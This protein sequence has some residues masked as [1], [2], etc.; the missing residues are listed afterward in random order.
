MLKSTLQ[1]GGNALGVF[2][3]KTSSYKY[4]W[5]SYY[6]VFTVVFCLR[7]FREDLPKL[8]YLTQ[9]IK[10][11]LRLNPP[12]IMIQRVTNEPM[13]MEGYE[14]PVGTMIN[15][16]IINILTNETTWEE[17]FVSIWV[18]CTLAGDDPPFGFNAIRK[19]QI[20]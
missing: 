1:K 13:T 15:I 16:I 3:L 10:E 4:N 5:W 7:I 2:Y 12:V 11:S 9:V 8:T 17:P 20:N 14:I 6:R 19:Q 18:E